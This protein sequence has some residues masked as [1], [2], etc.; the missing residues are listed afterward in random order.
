[1][2]AQP[3][4][5]RTNQKQRTR[6]AIVA[7]ARELIGSGAEV[8]MPRVA[9][10]ALVSEA[11]AYRYFPDLPSLIG[12]ALAGVWPPPADALAPVADSADPVER[13]AFACEFLLRGILARQGA[14]RAMIAATIT[15]PEAGSTRP[16]IRFGLIDH[17]LLPLE[18]TL[19]AADPDGF[20][21]LKRDLAVAVSAEALFTLTDLC[22]LD[23][24]QAVASAV[25][26][27]TTL[28]EAAVRRVG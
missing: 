26:T 28:T 14:V 17:A 22:G 13:I 10:A 16:G 8:T 24:E 11:T 1:M 25:H 20:T 23:P 7:A 15:Q 9:R 18:R 5:G 3:G 6:T 19:G 27:A 21:Q 4:T 12:E 2:A